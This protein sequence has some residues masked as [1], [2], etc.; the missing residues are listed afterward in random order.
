MRR[1]FVQTF[2]I[3]RFFST[4][5]TGHALQDA[6]GHIILVGVVAEI[7]LWIRLNPEHAVTVPA[8]M[9]KSP[10]PWPSGALIFF[11]NEKNAGVE[12][13]EEG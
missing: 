4:N 8:L 6:S 13:F 12:N 7:P 1:G 5:N 11:V 9:P 3:A 2:H 10:E